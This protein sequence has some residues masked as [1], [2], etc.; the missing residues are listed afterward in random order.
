MT[1]VRDERDEEREIADWREAFLAA[2]TGRDPAGVLSLLSHN[3]HAISVDAPLIGTPAV[4]ALMHAVWNLVP[5]VAEVLLLAGANTELRNDHGRGTLAVGCEARRP[6]EAAVER[7]R[8]LL[9]LYAGE[10][11]VPVRYALK[12]SA[13]GWKDEAFKRVKL[14]LATEMGRVLLVKP[15]WHPK[16]RTDGVTWLFTEETPM[17]EAVIK[18]VTRQRAGFDIQLYALNFEG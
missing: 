17:A 11:P 5:E 2:V 15:C 18:R 7:M 1:A 13:R 12:I 6:A 4:T 8:S 9:R 16:K 10:A 3:P 14:E